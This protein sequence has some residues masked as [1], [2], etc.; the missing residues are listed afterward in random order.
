MRKIKIYCSSIK[1]YSL[2]NKLPGYITPLGLGNSEFP[3]DWLKEKKGKNIMHL[4]QHYGEL[5]GF[6]WVWKNIINKYKEDDFIGF[7]HYR[8][9][10]LNYL[11]NTKKKNFNK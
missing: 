2:L 8:K 7:C 9:L 11:S 1:Y 6:Y 5:S 10:W 4:N 3:D